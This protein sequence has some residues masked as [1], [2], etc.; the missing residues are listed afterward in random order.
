[1]LGKQVFGCIEGLFNAVGALLCL[2]SARAIFPGGLGHD[3]PILVD[4]IIGSNLNST[5]AAC[6]SRT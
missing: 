6:Q 2:A 1:M 3:E 5:K 4:E